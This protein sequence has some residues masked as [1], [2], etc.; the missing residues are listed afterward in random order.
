M[1]DGISSS[2]SEAAH[3]HTMTAGCPATW[4][5]CSLPSQ[6]A[7]RSARPTLCRLPDEPRC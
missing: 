1:S 7:S 5:I 6:R 3:C 2:P 4:T